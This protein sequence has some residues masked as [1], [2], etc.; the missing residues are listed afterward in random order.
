MGARN[1]LVRICMNKIFNGNLK[2]S[3]EK[4]DFGGYPWYFNGLIHQIVYFKGNNLNI[5]ENIHKSSTLYCLNVVNL[6]RWNE[7]RIFKLSHQFK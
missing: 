4:M 3:K 5:T 2:I 1:R 7:I 6:I